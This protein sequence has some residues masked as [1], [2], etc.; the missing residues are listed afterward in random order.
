MEEA[1]YA[2]DE[3]RLKQVVPLLR[4]RLKST[5]DVVPIAGFFFADWASFEAPSADILI[6]RKM[7]RESTAAVLR[8]AIP[9]LQAL[10]SFGHDAQHSAVAAYAKS[11][12]FKNG[13][14]FG[15]LRAAVTGQKVS[16]PTFETME[17]L[18]KQESVRR[19]K[20]ALQSIT[21]SES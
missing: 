1:G 9:V 2:V 14:V 3:E 4:V 7:S 11:S 18:G 19:I 10:E 8:G 13:Q 12:G 17:I 15:S 20:L 21:G 6:Q 5:R 16:P